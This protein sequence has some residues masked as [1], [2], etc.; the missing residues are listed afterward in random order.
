MEQGNLEKLKYLVEER[1]A[2]RER[3]KVCEDRIAEK[4]TDLARILSEDGYL[5]FLRRFLK[6][7]H[8]RIK[9]TRTRRITSQN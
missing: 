1:K 9:G 4:S 3:L 7:Q 8:F 6:M 2:K 5:S